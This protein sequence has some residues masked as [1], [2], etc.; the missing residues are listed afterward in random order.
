MLLSEPVWALRALLLGPFFLL[1]ALLP[2]P[3]SLPRVLPPGQPSLLPVLPEQASEQAF[4][5]TAYKLQ[6]L[7]CRFFIN[8]V[9]I[10]QLVIDHDH[11]LQKQYRH[12]QKFIDQTDH[13]AARPIMITSPIPE[14]FEPV[15][16]APVRIEKTVRKI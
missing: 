6:K 3:F 2:E 8:R 11:M 9:L 16:K 14:A 12:H 13:E 5:L 15:Y 10:F 1:R 4:R 7:G